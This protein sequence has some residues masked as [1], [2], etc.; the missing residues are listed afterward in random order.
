ME[1]IGKSIIEKISSYNIFTNF[2]PG[3]V[4]AYLIRSFTRFEVDHVDMWEK[5]FV[6]Y[7]WGMVISRF[8]SIVIEPLLKKL[9]E[10]APSEHYIIVSEK[11]PFIRVLNESNNT[12]RSMIGVFFLMIIVK[13]YDMLFADYIISLGEATASVVE[14]VLLVLFLVLFVLSYRKQTDSIRKRVEIG[15]SE[16]SVSEKNQE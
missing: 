13:L 15:W 16:N 2:V 9:V 3:I 11:V 5:I 1:E 14:L 7:F 12:Y 4:F 6:Y 8:G 10:K